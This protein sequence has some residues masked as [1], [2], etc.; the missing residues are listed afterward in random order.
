MDRSLDRDRAADRQEPQRAVPARPP[1]PPGRALRGEEPATCTSSRW[2]SAAATTRAP[3][4]SPETKLLKQKAVQ[5][6]NRL[7]REFPDFHDADKVTFYLAHEHARARSVRRD[8]QDAGRADRASTPRARC[9]SRPS[10]SSATTT[11][12]R[13]T[14]PRPR[15]TTRPSSSCRR[16]P[17]ARP[18]PL[19]DGVDP[20][21]PGTSHATRS[22]SSRPPPA[23]APMPGVDSA[24]GA[25]RQA[26][27]AAR[28]GLQLH[29]GRAAQGRADVLREALRQ[30]HH[31]RARAGQ[32]GQPLL[33]QAAVRVG[34]PRAAQADG[35]PARSRSW[36]SSAAEKLY[37]SLKAAKGKVPHAAG[38][39]PVPGARRGER[40]GGSRSRTR[41]PAGSSWW[42]RRS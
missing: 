2:S 38:G 8:A 26:R 15:S 16:Q 39:H 35:D 27:G 20:G 3:I 36:T 31:L 10:R 23:S 41:P 42:R 9:G 24:E 34:H 6:Y 5:L 37:D 28:P 14:W 18:G 21:E 33:H 12:T 32:A 17:G 22:P 19:Q 40:E 25:Q 11:S 7:L 13:R 4:V 30:P 1:V 29:R